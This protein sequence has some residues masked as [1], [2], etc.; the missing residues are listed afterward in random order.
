MKFTNS[1]NPP[2]RSIVGE[3]LYLTGSGKEVDTGLSDPCFIKMSNPFEINC[4][5]AKP[6]K[7]N[8]KA[9]LGSE[10]EYLCKYSE[11]VSAHRL[12]KKSVMG[13]GEYTPC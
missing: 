9:F 2:L 13:E 7:V 6:I 5:E 3:R 10:F 4:S 8:G 12:H 1:Q 11:W